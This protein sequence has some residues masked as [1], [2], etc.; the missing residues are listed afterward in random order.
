MPLVYR[1][2]SQT[3]LG[4]GGLPLAGRKVFEQPKG[5][6]SCAT[7]GQAA[8]AQVSFGEWPGGFVLLLSPKVVLTI[9]DNKHQ[10]YAYTMSKTKPTLYLMLGY[11]GAG[12][13]TVAKIMREITNAVHIWEDQVRMERFG[14]PAMTQEES[15]D[16]HNYL[17]SLTGELLAAG[18]DVIY[19]TSFNAYEDRER[20]YR[21][22]GTCQA[23]T[24]LIWVNTDK[25][26]AHDRATKNTASQ[27]TR[28][29]ATILGDMDET[30]FQR[31]VQKL[32]PPR[33]NEP[34]TSVNGTNVTKEAVR[35][36]L[37]PGTAYKDSETGL[38][39]S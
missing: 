34:F 29:L 28:V 25:Q 37:Y 12:K 11:P 21:I 33:G 6:S 13:T 2:S 8:Q 14:R 16:L 31:F 3:D 30:T 18:K 17:N 5:A 38:T 27:P 19:D 15:D 4:L 9:V 39:R 10:V 20:M 36:V 7:Q 22:A 24:R 1:T 35:K 23:S 26:T 32:E